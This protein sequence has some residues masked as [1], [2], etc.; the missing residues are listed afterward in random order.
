MPANRPSPTLP[1]S[2]SG[3]VPISRWRDWASASSARYA[4]AA[5]SI[6]WWAESGA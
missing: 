3:A 5:R 6:S 2:S 4:V 1:I